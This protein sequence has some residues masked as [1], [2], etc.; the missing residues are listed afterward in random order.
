LTPEER[1]R[2][3]SLCSQIQEEKDYSRF[4][5]LLRE[6]NAVIG[7]KQRRFKEFRSY[8]Y[9]STK[10]R[11]WKTLTGIVTKTLT[12]TY[13]SQP[14]RLEVSIPEADD[15]F[16][17]IRIENSFTSPEGEE[18]GLHAGTRLDITL[19]AEALGADQQNALGS[20]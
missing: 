8:G 7:W 4:E 1:E 12:S 17:E 11:P 5:G 19:E 13:T 16:R 14:E 3:N 20:S 6:L 2:L 15:L 9:G 18:V 10:S